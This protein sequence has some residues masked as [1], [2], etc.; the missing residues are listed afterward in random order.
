MA[1]IVLRLVWL[2][3]AGP[4]FGILSIHFAVTSLK[5]GEFYITFLSS[6]AHFADM[7]A[8]L[9]SIVL[10]IYYGMLRGQINMYLPP[11]HPIIDI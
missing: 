6:I 9:N 10:N 3:L 11:E 4:D 8:I 5:E 2:V 1:F 7:A